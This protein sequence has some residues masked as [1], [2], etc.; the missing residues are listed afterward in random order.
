V[1]SSLRR[2]VVKVEATK[3]QTELHVANVVA[4]VLFPIVMGWLGAFT[5]DIYRVHPWLAVALWVLT[6]IS[7]GLFW[8]RAYPSTPALLKLVDQN[9]TLGDQIDELEITISDLGQSLNLLAAQATFSI[10]SRVMLVHY[11]KRG[12]S[13]VAEV[14]ECFSEILAPAYLDG[15]F[16][17]GFGGSERWNFAVYLYSSEQDLLVPVWREKAQNHPSA[18][19]GRSW[20]RGQ[21]HVGKA[22]V[23]LQTIITGDSQLE[24]VAQLSAAPTRLQRGYDGSTYRSFA[25]I[26]IGP[27]LPDKEPLPYG[28]LVATSD[29]VGRFDRENTA[30]LSQAAGIIGSLIALGSLEIDRLRDSTNDTVSPEVES[31]GN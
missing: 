19:M 22:F 7:F 21:G 2:D 3:K 10:S 6:F 8:W 20:G 17:F 11:L 27:M 12:I 28:V 13:T 14:R 31:H 9:E 16:L 23:D 18:G 25:A 4:F 29:R 15:E 24:E 30:V 1:R 26:P 5:S